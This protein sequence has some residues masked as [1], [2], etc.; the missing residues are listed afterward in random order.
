MTDR[1]PARCGNCRWWI[2]GAPANAAATREPGAAPYHGACHVSPP[3]ASAAHWSG[4]KVGWFPI[5]HEDRFCAEWEEPED[6]GGPDG[7]E[8][9][10]ADQG[11]GDVVPIRRDLAA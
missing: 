3:V 7:G 1:I 10:P 6:D 5:T 4:P 11:G 2:P 9:V 8:E